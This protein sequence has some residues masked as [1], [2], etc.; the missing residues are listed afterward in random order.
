MLLFV[1]SAIFYYHSLRLSVCVLLLGLLSI[2]LRS[3]HCLSA[4]LHLIAPFTFP[5]II[6]Y[7]TCR[8]LGMISADSLP[9]SVLLAIPLTLT[10]CG[11]ISNHLTSAPAFTSLS[12]RSFHYFIDPPSL[13]V[14][15]F[16]LQFNPYIVSCSP[17]MP[18]HHIML[19]LLLFSPLSNFS[20]A[21]LNDL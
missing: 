4:R 19:A 18:L 20:S 2:L 14:L 3:L 7:F 17:Q 6:F 1:H 8:I 12:C 5:F 9:L 16:L 10:E 15:H 11:F 13:P 21:T